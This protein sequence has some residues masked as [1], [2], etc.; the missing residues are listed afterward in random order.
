MGVNLASWVK[1]IFFWAKRFASQSFSSDGFCGMKQLQC[2]SITT[3]PLMGCQSIWGYPTAVYQAS[4]TW[5][6]T[7]PTYSWSERGN[8]KDPERIINPLNPKS[9]QLLISPLNSA[10]NQALRSQESRNW[11]PTK[12]SLDC[13]TNFPCRCLREQHGECV[14][15]LDCKRLTTNHLVTVSPTILLHVYLLVGN[16]LFFFF[17]HNLRRNCYKTLAFILG[18]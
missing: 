15:T 18:L 2:R 13:W 7:T 10:L 3:L 12:K 1:S 6:N 17:F 16:I 4:L 5:L 11:S 8:V 9:D 14:L